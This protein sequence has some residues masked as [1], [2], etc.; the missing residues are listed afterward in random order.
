LINFASCILQHASRHHAGQELFVQ[1]ISARCLSDEA[2][3]VD[4]SVTAAS[5]IAVVY[6]EQD[7]LDSAEEFAR[8][9]LTPEMPARRPFAA[10]NLALLYYRRGDYH[11]ARKYR[12]ILESSPT[13]E[14]Q[15][16]IA[17][18]ALVLRGL[19]SVGEQLWDLAAQIEREL[20]SYTPV[21][22]LPIDP[23]T[24]HE[25]VG[26]VIAV[27]KGASEAES[28]LLAK[29]AKTVRFDYLAAARLALL[30]TNYFGRDKTA[31]VEAIVAPI[32]DR[33]SRYGATAVARQA[34]RIL[35]SFLS[36]G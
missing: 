1:I 17:V 31:R 7:K 6:M 4:F 32:M 18:Q 23:S 16:W 30:A 25:F 33:A 10:A 29:S 22:A 11:T 15:K 13:R 2:G 35:A 34:S 36:T 28:Y 12:E 8:K 14:F 27:R 9:A 3:S 24:V 26:Q 5:N 21:D 20:A 19:C